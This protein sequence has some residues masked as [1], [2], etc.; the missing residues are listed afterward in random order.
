MV[1]RLKQFMPFIVQA[2]PQASP[3]NP[4]VIFNGQW[5]AKKISDN[6]DSLI[7]I[8][9]SVRGTVTHNYSANANAFSALKNIQFRNKLYKA[10]TKQ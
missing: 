7:E 9:L 5:L 10:P 8:G 6:I 2:I 1:V 3:A 4:E